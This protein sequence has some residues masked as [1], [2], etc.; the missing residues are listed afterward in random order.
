MSGFPENLQKFCEPSSNV[1]VLHLACTLCKSV[2]MVFQE[3]ILSEECCL[4]MSHYIK[5]K[6][7]F[8]MIELQSVS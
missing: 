1:G 2:A 4:K 5:P 7:M 8:S 3:V 6:L